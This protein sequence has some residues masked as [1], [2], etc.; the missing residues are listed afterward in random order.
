M[1]H[2]WATSRIDY[3]KGEKPAGCILC[4]KP[5]EQS[6][7][8]EADRD[9]LI[10][11]R[12]AHAFVMMNLYPYNNG[13]LMV[14]PYLHTAAIETLAADVAADL[15]AT[16]QI[17]IAAL[18]K[19]MKPDGINVGLNLGKTAGAAIEHHLHIHI[20][21]RWE[22]DTNFMTVA[23]QTRVIPQDVRETYL[24]LKPFFK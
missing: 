2:L 1:D 14:S 16:V 5:K 22:G 13:H 3:I 20:V 11:K 6:D 7:Q 19:A 21:P 23:S 10:L 8:T 24:Q 15:M 12:N 17:S 9:N 18:K 4:D